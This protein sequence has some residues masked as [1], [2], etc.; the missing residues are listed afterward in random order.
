MDSIFDDKM[1]FENIK[2]RFKGYIDENYK[3]LVTPN[4]ILINDTYRTIK[5][6]T[7]TIKRLI[8]ENDN[9]IIMAHGS[10]WCEL[11]YNYI[12][13]IKYKSNIE[14]EKFVDKLRENYN[15][16]FLVDFKYI[17]KWKVLYGPS[18]DYL[19]KYK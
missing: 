18:I 11:T 19:E 4:N 16:N 9:I 12:T 7:K 5:Q 3:S 6:L 8:S 1:S 13:K 2:L 10:D 15:Y 17:D 14:Y